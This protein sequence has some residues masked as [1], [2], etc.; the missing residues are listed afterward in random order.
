MLVDIVDS[1]LPQPQRPAL[2]PA[3]GIDQHEN[4]LQQHT[5]PPLDLP[6]VP[7]QSPTQ[8]I[9]FRT[10]SSKSCGPSC[11]CACHKMSQLRSPGL[12][13]R[14]LGSLFIGYEA[15]PLVTKPCNSSP[16][17]RGNVSRTVVSYI[18]SRWF[19][20]CV[21]MLQTRPPTPEPVLR[22]LRIGPKDSEIFKR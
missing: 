21:V 12:F 16:C 14:L 15:I 19:L 20:N 8:A 10:V 17:A 9:I 3:I 11:S 13:D 6:T 7:D 5:T 18:F 2:P 1:T 22:I 4:G